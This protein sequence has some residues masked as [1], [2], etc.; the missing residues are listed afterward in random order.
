[1]RKQSLCLLAVLAALPVAT[2]CAQDVIVG[3]TTG[4]G[5]TTGGA[6]TGSATTGGAYTSRLTGSQPG[7]VTVSSPSGISY[8][9]DSTEVS[10]SAYAL[11]LASSPV[12]D[13][14]SA[15]CGWK[16]TFQP[17][18]EPKDD[19]Y[20]LDGPLSCSSTTTHFDPTTIGSEP[21][22]CVDWCDAAAYCVWAG[23][24]LCGHVGGGPGNPEGAEDDF[25]DADNSQWYN[26]CSNGGTTP[27]P[28]G[29]TYVEGACNDGPAVAPVGKTAGCHAATAPA[30]GIFDLSGNVGEWED[31][32]E[33]D[34]QCCYIRG[35]NFSLGSIPGDPV[36]PGTD[37]IC[38]S[39][40]AGDDSTGK[41]GPRNYGDQT[42]GFRC[43]VD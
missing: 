18:L 35:G 20:G 21:V 12:P 17:G 24:R 34:G 22:V 27:F 1:M 3:V 15:S 41:C 4:G 37:F 32:C 33:T 23:K 29:A 30:S 9:I 5:A 40:Y 26:A 39:V 43:C 13:P 36:P 8:S 19:N 2:G 25:S 31:D 16:T 38:G 28:Y 14:T 10:Q 6:T 11:F 7:M 42:T